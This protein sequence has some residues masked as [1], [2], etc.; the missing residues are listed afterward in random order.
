MPWWYFGF[1]LTY[2]FPLLWWA[3]LFAPVSHEVIH[4]DFKRRA[5][6]GAS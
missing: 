1:P 6:I 3:P 4:V 2:Y 5:V